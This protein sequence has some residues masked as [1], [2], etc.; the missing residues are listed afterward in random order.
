MNE[1][2]EECG[3]FGIVCGST[4]E[5]A[6]PVYYGLYALQHRGQES[7]GIAVCDDG[8]L[9]CYKQA[10]LVGEALTPAVRAGLGQGNMAVGH[11]RYGTTGGSDV[12][13]AQ[14]IM[15]NHKNGRM[16]LVHNGNLANAGPLRAKL[17]ERGAIF[18]TASD[19]E[20]IAYLITQE[21]LKSP[22]IE[23][24]VRRAARRLRGACSPIVSSPT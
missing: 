21:R 17:E 9:H 11:V 19:S 6:E 4:Q 7:C 16:A 1:I 8:Y 12:R 24:A 18:H 15:V 22:C 2:H 5:V 10:G 3:V 14:P 13:N 23:E 20:I